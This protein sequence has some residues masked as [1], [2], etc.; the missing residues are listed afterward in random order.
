MFLWS[1]LVSIHKKV[2]YWYQTKTLQSLFF[3]LTWI[4][5]VFGISLFT[6]RKAKRAGGI[7][8]THFAFVRG[9]FWKGLH[10]ER[11]AYLFNL[12]PQPIKRLHDKR[13]DL[14][15]MVL[16]VYNRKLD[17]LA[18]TVV[19]YHCLSYQIFH[20]FLC[21][22][23]CA[24]FY[25]SHG[26]FCFNITVPN[27]SPILHIVWHTMSALRYISLVVFAICPLLTIFALCLLVCWLVQ[28]KVRFQFLRQLF[29]IVQCLGIQ[30]NI[31]IVKDYISR[32][33]FN[34]SCFNI[35][36]MAEVY[37]VKLW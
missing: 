11:K 19:V 25:V 36:S 12:L 18:C 2:F 31:C 14:H 4:S 22:C 16:L 26:V 5:K 34:I 8:G 1:L 30:R 15:C 17:L 32:K 20:C 3:S 9:V 37:L 10:L 24:G 33:C 21:I 27:Q 29:A 6:K 7:E 13:Y 35:F 23:T 28:P